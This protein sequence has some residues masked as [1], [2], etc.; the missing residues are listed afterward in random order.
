MENVNGK[1]F[2]GAGE[3]QEGEY[4]MNYVE[5]MEKEEKEVGEMEDEGMIGTQI[6]FS[7]AGCSGDETE[8]DTGD[9]DEAMELFWDL[10]EENGYEDVEIDYV[11]HRPVEE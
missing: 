8:F 11:E 4:K 3:H 2:L 5:D 9:E 10:C 7:Y 1:H 6:G